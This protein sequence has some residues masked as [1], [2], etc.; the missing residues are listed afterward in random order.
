MSLLYGCVLMFGCSWIVVCCLG[1]FTL[2]G[3]GVWLF[4]LV[5]SYGWVLLFVVGLW[6]CGLVVSRR[7]VCIL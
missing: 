3:I 2:I 7:L 5:F 6:T 4:G 1:L